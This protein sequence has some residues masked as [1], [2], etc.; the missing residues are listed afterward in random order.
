MAAGD[1]LPSG[2]YIVMCASTA[3]AAMPLCL[4][5]GA[6]RDAIGTEIQLYGVDARDSQM[7]TVFDDQGDG[8]TQKIFWPACGRA[9]DVA[10]GVMADGTDIRLWDSWSF[11]DYNNLTQ[12]FDIY[13]T[14]ETATY[15]GKSYPAYKILCHKDNAY[16]IETYGT[17]PAA[18]DNVDI[19]HYDTADGAG[20]HWL[21]IP[22]AKV[23]N[24]VYTIRSLADTTLCLAVSGGSTAELAPCAI[25]KAVPDSNSQTYKVTTD[26]QGNVRII[27][28]VKR[29]FWLG[30][31]P[32][33]KDDAYDGAGVRH[34]GDDR[35]T[36]NR[37]NWTT[38][39]FGSGVDAN[40]N[41]VP[42]FRI[43]PQAAPSVGYDLDAS[44]GKD[45]DSIAETATI[46]K[47]S[48]LDT[49]TWLFWPTEQYD[50]GLGTPSSVMGLVNDVRTDRFFTDGTASVRPAW[51]YRGTWWDG[52]NIRYRT[53]SRKVGGS[54]SAWGPWR[55]DVNG[56]VG[57]DGW[58]M[59]G[60]PSLESSAAAN[61]TTTF[62]G[63]YER[64]VTLSRTGT[65]RMD[66]EYEV[67]A[68]SRSGGV[69]NDV[70]H[71]PSATGTVIVAWQPTVRVTG[72]AMTPTG[73]S[74]MYDSDHTRGGNLVRAE[75]VG[76][77]SA[78]STS[79]PA[80]GAVDVPLSSLSH[81]PVEGEAVTVRLWMWT[82]D[83][84]AAVSDSQQKLSYTSGHGATLKPT[85]TVYGASKQ[86]PSYSAVA[87]GYPDGTEFYL[88]IRRGHGD[89]MVKVDPSR[90]LPPLG[91]GWQLFATYRSGSSWATWLGS[92][93][94]IK[95][96]GW[97]VDEADGSNGVE[98]WVNEG[99]GPQFAP[100]YEPDVTTHVTTGRERPVVTRGQTVK[101]TWSLDGW[102]GVTDPASERSQADW[103]AHAGKVT[104]RS[105]MGFWANAYVTDCKVDL[106]RSVGGTIS[107]SFVEVE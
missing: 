91:V 103:L 72:V 57:N 54:M 101:A 105:P 36:T 14:T 7:V 27:S 17:A 11:S 26:E 18:F 22:Q 71:G 80:S 31:W 41:N 44:G 1:R 74:V 30:V 88:V 32:T 96:R 67:R 20:K 76:L 40:G 49:Q 58:G 29:N 92:F 61:P 48:W 59:P 43:V 95:A 35:S 45:S 19:W 87:S 107:A 38:Q 85:V 70:A 46:Q 98:V 79:A 99:E 50:A 28:A 60:R 25:E 42:G 75:V 94:A 3:G 90:I 106:S 6:G 63:R 56:S 37:I 104:F 55:W 81:A 89:R 16:C 9:A 13:Q 39:P 51:G 23:T 4:D 52:F 69:L 86:G 15:G 100:T 12:T 64:P 8:G 65:D 47:A 53:R 77:G 73:L 102:L 34:T 5:V 33:D 84:A 21:F 68:F 78:R 83:G 93:D 24:G 10:D 82:S 62:A 66:V 97:L 2:T